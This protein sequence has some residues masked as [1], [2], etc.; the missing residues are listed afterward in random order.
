M[1]LVKIAQ[2]LRQ[3]S[4]VHIEPGFKCLERILEPRPAA[5]AVVVIPSIFCTTRRVLV[6]KVMPAAVVR[7]PARERS[8]RSTLSSS[9]SDPK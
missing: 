5:F 7:T 9:S 2:M 6:M 8:N 3:G 4:Q 1:G